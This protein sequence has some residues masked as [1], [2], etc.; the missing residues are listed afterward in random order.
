MKAVCDYCDRTAHGTRDELIAL[1][2]SGATVFTSFRRT[3]TA[4]RQHRGDLVVDMLT[5]FAGVRARV[6]R[7]KEVVA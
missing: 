2:W 4:C 1:G 3:F 6:G 5:A 7:R